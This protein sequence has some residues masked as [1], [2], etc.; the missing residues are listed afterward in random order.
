MPAPI[1]CFVIIYIISYKIF[2]NRFS[3]ISVR[4]CQSKNPESKTVV[5]SLTWTGANNRGHESERNNCF[6]KI[7]LA[8]VKNIENNKILAS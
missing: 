4:S 3:V 1:L 7:Q 2:Y 6:S 5:E 8:Q